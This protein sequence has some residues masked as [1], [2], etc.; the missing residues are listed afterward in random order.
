MPFATPIPN[1]QSTLASAYTAGS[2]SMTLTSATS[3]GTLTGGE[4]LRISAF[5]A[6]ATAGTP[7]LGRWKVTAISGNVLTISGTLDGFADVNLPSNSI[8]AVTVNDG[9]IDDL[10]SIF[11]V[12]GVYAGQYGA[13]GDAKVVTDAAITAASHALSSTSAAF[14]T[15][16][17]GKA[18][19]INGAG[20]AGAVFAATIV[21]VAAGVATLSAAA[22]TTVSAAT[23]AYGT[24]NTTAFQN[25]IAAAG[26]NASAQQ[27]CNVYTGTGNFLFAGSIGNFPNFVSLV[28]SHQYGPANTAQ[29]TDTSSYAYVVNVQPTAGGTTF[30]LT[31]GAGTYDPAAVSPP[32][33]ISLFTDSR[34][35][36][37]AFYWPNQLVSFSTPILYPITIYVG[38]GSGGCAVKYCHFVNPYH[39]MYCEKNLAVLIEETRGT[40]IFRGYVLKGNNDVSRLI[41]VFTEATWCGTLEP[42]SAYINANLIAFEL[43]RNDLTILDHCFAFFPNIAYHFVDDPEHNANGPEAAWAQLRGGGSD[44]C[45]SYNVLVEQSQPQ[46]I[47]ID[48]MHFSQISNVIQIIFISSTNTGSVRIRNCMMYN[49]SGLYIVDEGSGD[50]SVDNCKMFGTL[51]GGI[52]SSSFPET[53]AIDAIGTGSIAVRNNTFRDNQ[54]HVNI[55]STMNNAIVTGNMSGASGQINV[56]NSIGSAAVIANNQV[57]ASPNFTL[58]ADPTSVTV[59]QG[60]TATTTVSLDA[61]D[62]YTG[63]AA[64]SVT[65][66]LPTGV[67]AAFSPTSVTG[68][69][70]VTSTLTFT[71]A[72]GAT[73]ESGASVT[74]QA[75]DSVNSITRTTTVT[76][77]VAASGSA[78]FTIAASPSSVTVAQSSTST[79]TITMTPTGGYTGTAAL[80]VIAGLPTGVT[81]AF[82]PTSLTG[83]GTVESTLTFTASGSATVESGASITV[84]ALDT[85]NSIT[86]DTTVTLTVT[87]A[88]GLLDTFM[89]TGLLSANNADT[90]QAW[91]PT[92]GESDFDSFL[93]VDNGVLFTTNTVG[94]DAAVAFASDDASVTVKVLGT[95]VST[96]DIGLALRCAGE[97]NGIGYQGRFLLGSGWQIFFNAN[98]TQTQ[99]GSNVAGTLNNGDVIRFTASGSGATVTLTLFQNGTQVAQST[100]SGSSRLTATGNVGIGMFNPGGASTT[101]YQATRMTAV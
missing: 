20:T 80:S 64:L 51:A 12:Q 16:D 97:G 61:I 36:G 101:N 41:G 65:A 30:L 46:G 96:P 3:F 86:Q 1:A 62:G 83:G 76:L 66:G 56:T 85:V 13:K 27:G 87:A 24:D 77:T 82:A 7:C 55:G 67:T 35:V 94:S 75:L 60:S 58:S 15:A 26:A 8:I 38:L 6:D 93:T 5:A 70:T 73:V 31:G 19:S 10:T 29:T 37:I 99:L 48:G 44:V 79:T 39:I 84:Q 50:V 17:V 90:G 45:G 71:A 42:I 88:D 57:A 47:D 49:F 72:E 43:G 52:T 54:P 100:D 63:T 34:V 69:G 40:P 23:A 91:G 89:G 18:V 2:G 59:T 11:N 32:A 21:S 81:A 95:I 53:I 68:G 14:T 25:A 9:T 74:V 28:G 98:G 22:V 4:F 78:N 33:F 92:F